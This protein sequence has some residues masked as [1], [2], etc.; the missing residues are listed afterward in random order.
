MK[1]LLLFTASFIVGFAMTLAF[2]FIRGKYRDWK[3]HRAMWRALKWMELS[4]KI[5]MEKK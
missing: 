5:F 3:M 4:H 2:Y 1:T